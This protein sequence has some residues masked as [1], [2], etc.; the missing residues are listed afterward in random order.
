M[1]EFCK[2]G[3]SNHCV[4]RTVVGIIQSNGA[5]AE[6]VKIPVGS[7]HVLPEGV[8]LEE[9]VFVEPLA[10]AIQT[11]ELTLVKKGDAVVVLGVGRLGVLICAFANSLGA[12]VIAV[13]RSSWKLERAKKLGAYE[14]INSSTEDL[15]NK[16]K[17]ITNGIGADIVVEST[18]TPEG[19]NLGL[20]LT[21]PRGTLAL[22]TT[23][24]LDTV[25][26]NSTK[27]VV[28]EICIQGS[29][30]GPF[31]KAIEILKKRELPVKS[32]ISHVYPLTEL[33]EALIT[34]Y[35]ASKVLIEF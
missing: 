30:C 8:S 28:N 24:G 27:V 2:I 31:D 33:R 7:V 12:K 23:C 14:V 17:D 34:A 5:F 32:I 16:I 21:R 25:N 35:N 3:I 20:E 15:V 26:V 9:G 19:F 11:F 22:K 6:L 10:A 4:K 1:C 29:R 13:S 18:G